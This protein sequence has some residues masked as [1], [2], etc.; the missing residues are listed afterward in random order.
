MVGFGLR[1]TSTEQEKTRVVCKRFHIG[2]SLEEPQGRKQEEVGKASRAPI[3]RELLAF[4]V[5]FFFFERQSQPVNVLQNPSLFAAS[6]LRSCQLWRPV[7]SLACQ[8]AV[9]SSFLAERVPELSSIS[10]GDIR[11]LGESVKAKGRPYQMNPGG[12]CLKNW[13]MLFLYQMDKTRPTPET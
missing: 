5:F 8:L 4:H 7:A 3:Q 2:S 11:L 1:S 13:H 6:L 12:T 10:N 9:H